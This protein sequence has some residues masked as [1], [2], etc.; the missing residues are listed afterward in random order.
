MKGLCLG[1]GQL[2]L[3]VGVEPEGYGGI[4]I[5]GENVSKWRDWQKVFKAEKYSF[6][7]VLSCSGQAPSATNGWSGLALGLY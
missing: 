2:S 5:K 4:I 3:E 1:N 7:S 6:T